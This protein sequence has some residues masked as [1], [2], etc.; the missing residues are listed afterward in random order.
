[1][2]GSG[3]GFRHFDAVKNDRVDHMYPLD[4]TQ[5]P[6]ALQCDDI[7]LLLTAGEVRG[8]REKPGRCGFD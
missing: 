7:V 1:M 5:V 6:G 8:V 2:G 4:P 3:R